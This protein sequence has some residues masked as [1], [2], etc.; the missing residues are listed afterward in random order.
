VIFSA[1]G[2]GVLAWFSAQQATTPVFPLEGE[3]SSAVTTTVLGLA[4][5]AA[6]W[7]FVL[8][9]VLR[10]ADTNSPYWT[11]TGVKGGMRRTVELATSKGGGIVLTIAAGLVLAYFKHLFG[12]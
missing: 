5:G 2:G 6:V 11:R 7:G 10:S 12:W 4:V 9:R 1:V 8:E 3:G